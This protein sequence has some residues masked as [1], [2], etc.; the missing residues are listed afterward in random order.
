MNPLLYPIFFTFLFGLVVFFLPKRIPFLTSFLSIVGALAGFIAAINLIGKINL[1]ADWKWFRIDNFA[2]AL[3]FKLT[4]LGLLA[5]LFITFFGVIISIFSAGYYAKRTISRFYF[6]YILWTISAS[7]G[8]V[9]ANNL[10]VLL[11]FWELA[12]LLLYFLINMGTGTANQDAGKTFTILGLSDVLLLL[13][14]VLTMVQYNTL[15]I[16]D[17]TIQVQDEYS[18]AIFLCFLIAAMAKAGAIP[19]HTWIPAIAN[20]APTPVIAL[21]P[22]AIDKLLGIYFL[23][24]INISMF[25]VSHDLSLVMLIVGAVTIIISVMMAL[26]QHDLK[27]LLS[28]HAISQ[29]GYMILGIGTGSMVGVIGGLFHMINNTLYKSCLFLG[30]AIVEDKVGTTALDKL[31]GLA[32]KLPITFIT[33]LVAAFA[34]SGIPPLNGF[35]S[36]WL[37]YQSLID[38]KQPFF[39][40]AAMFGSALTL[41][42]FVKI[43]HSIFFGAVKPEFENVTKEKFSMA[44]PMIVLA[45]LC[46]GFG[47]FA[48]LPMNDL[49]IPAVKSSFPADAL[50][51]A[52][53]AVWN[54]QLAT[55]LLVIGLVLGLFILL[56]GRLLTRKSTTMEVFIGGSEYSDR[57]KPVPG[58]DFYETITSMRVLKTIYHDGEKGTFDIYNLGGSLG[59]LIVQS[60]RF[61]HNGIVSTYLSWCIIGLGILLFILIR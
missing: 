47:V 38:A 59:N 33:M 56:L 51:N 52:G 55:A 14:I 6:P 40:V 11:I 61:I 3:D 17:L 4:S 1:I 15:R 22:G 37:I 21:L 30:G 57:L 8:I 50:P 39:L 27:K 42:S 7:A 24:L 53:D 58:T 34:I 29:V 16:S 23:A 26:I 35:F 25:K 48:Y 19:M 54:P 41:A 20:S 18:T 45:L 36:K 9:I 12:T 43:I 13:G 46:I 10:L 5:L 28:F 31:G 49:L 2:F 44:L 32:R 60:L